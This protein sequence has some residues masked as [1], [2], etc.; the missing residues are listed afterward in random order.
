MRYIS[1]SIAFVSYILHIYYRWARVTYRRYGLLGLLD[2]SYRPKR[3][4]VG[5]GVRHN[6]WSRA[7]GLQT[8]GT[9]VW[10]IIHQLEMERA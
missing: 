5:V 4:A 8:G 6:P 9:R 7:H 10:S 2:A 3:A 1:G